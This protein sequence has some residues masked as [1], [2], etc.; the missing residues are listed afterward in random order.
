[1][2]SPY[3]EKLKASGPEA[4][5]FLRNVY[6]VSL[7]RGPE[8]LTPG[9]SDNTCWIWQLSDFR[10]RKISAHR[11]AYEIFVG[12]IPP[13]RFVKRTCGSELCVNPRH[14]ELTFQ[15]E[16]TNWLTTEQRAQVKAALA[17]G[18]PQTSIARRF[19][20]TQGAV[21]GIKN[22]TTKKR[23]EVRRPPCTTSSL[24]EWLNKQSGRLGLVGQLARGAAMPAE[25]LERALELANKEFTT[26]EG[27]VREYE[28]RR[29]SGAD[30][31]DAA[32]EPSETAEVVWQ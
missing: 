20:I 2:T 7:D 23:G 1:M 5:A 3:F 19:N 31:E 14:L 8:P 25:T 21:S 6:P 32:P 9:A 12:P 17:D 28:N 11:F 4:A 29:R 30:A 16:S 10:F 26:H 22:G 15:H 24:S 13:A 27:L 18:E